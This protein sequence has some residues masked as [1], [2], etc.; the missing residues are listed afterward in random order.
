VLTIVEAG[1]A[2]WREKIEEIEKRA[3]LDIVG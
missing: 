3:S 2:G 1:S